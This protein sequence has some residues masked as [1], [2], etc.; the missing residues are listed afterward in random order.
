MEPYPKERLLIQ[1]IRHVPLTG[2]GSQ[3]VHAPHDMG[4][5]VGQVIAERGDLVGGPGWPTVHTAL[6]QDGVPHRRVH[7]HL[8]WCTGPVQQAGPGIHGHPQPPVGGRIIE[9]HRTRHAAG[10][11]SASA[12]VD[13]RLGTCARTGI[14]HT[15]VPQADQQGLIG[16]HTHPLAM[17]RSM[18]D[19]IGGSFLPGDAKPV[20]GVEHVLHVFGPHAFLVQVVN[21]EPELCTHTLGKG[22]GEQKV[23]CV[24]S[25]QEAARCGCDAGTWYHDRWVLRCGC[26]GRDS[27][28]H[29]PY[30][31]RDFKSLVSTISPPGPSHRWW[32]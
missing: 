13:N 26:P 6:Q 18:V 9:P 14:Q 16:R 27:N 32:A 22:L 29:S 30:G 31:P 17:V 23:Q 28:P 15:A 19:G 21:A 1:H 10:T 8:R 2:A 12:A 20:Q 25:V 11:T 4:G 5:A 7:I 24:A 3:K